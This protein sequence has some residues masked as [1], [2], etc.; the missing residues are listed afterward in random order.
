[1]VVDEQFE[2][3]NRC[4]TCCA[5]TYWK[6]TFPRSCYKCE[7]LMKSWPIPWLEWEAND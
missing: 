6:T 1:M 5:Q 2:I 3:G 7:G 4:S